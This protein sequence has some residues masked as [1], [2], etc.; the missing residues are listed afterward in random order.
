MVGIGRFEM[1]RE[2]VKA[3]TRVRR[4][5]EASVSSKVKVFDRI[6][7]FHDAER[8]K[9]PVTVHFNRKCKGQFIKKSSR[10]CV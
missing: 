10:S 4:A 7:V 3:R 2:A 9:F 1:L 5:S 6:P 8:L